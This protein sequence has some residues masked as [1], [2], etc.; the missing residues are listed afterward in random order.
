M[1]RLLRDTAYIGETFS[2]D[3]G[4]VTTSIQGAQTKTIVSIGSKGNFK[5]TIQVTAT[6]INGM[7]TLLSWQEI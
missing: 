1:L 4:M 2:V 3:D 7:L 5:K 6:I